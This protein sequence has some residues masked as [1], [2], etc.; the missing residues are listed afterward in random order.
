MSTVLLG[1]CDSDCRQLYFKGRR[2]RQQR[3]E[4]GGRGEGGDF[5][6]RGR[7]VAERRGGSGDASRAGQCL[8]FL[9]S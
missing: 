8:E 7:K 3:Q 4:G 6:S 2:G 5:L 1:Y 9:I